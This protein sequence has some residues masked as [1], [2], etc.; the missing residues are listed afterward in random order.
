MARRTSE[1]CREPAPEPAK[2]QNPDRA[3]LLACG[4][5][6]LTEH[7]NLSL[8][9]RIAAITPD[10]VA[11]TVFTPVR[12]RVRLE[13]AA[14][15]ALVADYES[16]ATLGQV[17]KKYGV[18]ISTATRCVT[19][20]RV[21]VRQQEIKVRLED[22][23]VIQELHRGGMSLEAIGRQYGC[24]GVAVVKRLERYEASLSPS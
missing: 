19:S 4:A 6:Q 9:E 16:G 18:H 2:E 8:W 21:T 23:P 7:W 22:L 20:T 14:R 24:S 3:L 12:R 5:V 11:R 10:G 15:V 17:A 1:T 13:A